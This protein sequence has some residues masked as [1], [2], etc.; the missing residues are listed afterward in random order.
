[1]IA[2]K[3]NLSVIRRLWSVVKTHKRE[4]SAGQGHKY[5]TWLLVLLAVLVIF[6]YADTLTGP[7]IFD[8][9]NNIE[10]N[11]HIRISQIT[12]KNLA[13]AAL[14]SPS[15][16][17]P[18]A[19]ISFALNYYLHGYNVVGF[20]LV[21][22]IIHVISGILLYFFIQTTFHTPALRSRYAHYKWISFFAAAIWVVHPLQTQSISYIVQRMNSLSAMFYILS[23][24]LYA[25]LRVKPQKRSK[26]WLLS[27][28]AIAGILAL[29]S[30]ENAA[31]LPFFIILYEW[32][33]F[34]NLSLKWLKDH[35]LGLAGLLLLLA[36][37][38]L[39]YLGV[40]PLDKILATYGSRHFTPPQR[41][42]TEL[43]VVIFYIGLFLWPHPSRLNLDH[44]FALSYSLTDPIT[45]LFSML[46]IAVLMA[47]AVITARN[48]RI[49]SFCILWFLG[50]LVIESSIFGLEII[51]EHRLYLPTMMCSLIL[52]LLVY[53][54]VKPIWLKAVILCALAIVG[55]V[56]THERNEVWRDRITIWQDCVKKSPQ[57]ARPYNN[58][59]VAL[60]DQGYYDEAIGQY[61]KALQIKPNY[62]NALANLGSTLAKQG[63]VEEGI[64][65][66]FKALELEPKDYKTLNNLGVALFT[67]NRHKEAITYLSE[68]LEIS[69]HFAKAHN[70]LGVAL[71]RQG[72]V[73]EAVDHFLFA[74]QLDPEYAEAHNNLGV[75]LANQGQYQEAI[76]QF[77]AALKINPGYLQA[78]Q[79]KE[80]E[81]LSNLG[82][83]LL[84]QN[85]YNEAIKYLSEALEINPQFAKAHNNLGMALQRQGWFQEAMDHF[86][87]AVQLD[88]DYAEAY[89]NRGVA[90]AN[91]G[92]YEEAIEQ[93]SAALEIN[94]G[95]T[96]ARQN[97][98]KSLKDKGN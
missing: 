55:S 57:K 63:K 35:I 96:Q 58:L 48:Q 43:R 68:A 9:K 65:Q 26:W 38:V 1:V 47:L 51:F 30:K 80:Y 12:L 59:G 94:P 56:W 78:R 37:I 81:T 85:R 15:Y 87:S 52:V 8:D 23:F 36:I 77:S 66:F 89:N 69:P 39:I 67:Q 72:R 53:R 16:R 54:W 88:P 86:Q 83:A 97:L 3:P 45:T 73:Q 91:Q 71:Q 19:N 92:R 42:L 4:P 7:F 44:D 21:N 29:G 14:D 49:I 79:N 95:Y 82:V 70:N 5:E 46:A 22:L 31:T 64:V 25:H 13:T 75:A 17:R 84:G 20:H 62:S 18:V 61:Q 34:R 93:F 11:H 74:L 76:E 27:G 10:G 2:S 33:F 6:I 50:N 41:L 60:T 28:C 32:Y 98:E 24:L 40:D 90:L